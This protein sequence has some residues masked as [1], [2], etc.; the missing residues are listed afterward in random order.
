MLTDNSK[1]KYIVAN[2]KMNPVSFD[3]ADNLIKTIKK[4]IKKSD[5]I[6]VVICPPTV[7]LSKIKVNSDF[8]LGVQNIFWED[9]GAYTGEISAMMVKN[10]KVNHIIIGHSERR[11]YLNETD[12]MVNLKVQSVIKNNLISI[13]CIGETIKEK[14]Q[15]RTSEVIITQLEE[16]LKNVELQVLNCN[17][18]IAYEPI[19]AIGTGET[20]SANEIMSACLL[21]KKTISNLYGRETAEKI[22]ILYGGSVNSKNAF[23]FIDKTGMDG[24]LIGGASL[25]GSEFVR[26]VNLFV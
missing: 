4:G 21:I 25:N 7:Y 24:L 26:I 8:E 11:K 5:S 14:Q 23:D 19:W 2:W 15:D 18:Q 22:P 10:L 13:L 17:L 1:L 20:P 6:S 3:E 16:A 9:K 12:E